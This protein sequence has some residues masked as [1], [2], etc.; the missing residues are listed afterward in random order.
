MDDMGAYTQAIDEQDYKQDVC[1]EE[2]EDT[3]IGLEHLLDIHEADGPDSDDDSD[4]EYRD[5]DEGSVGCAYEI[6]Q[7]RSSVAAACDITKELREWNWDMPWAERLQSVAKVIKYVSMLLD[8]LKTRSYPEID[9]A[10]R[11]YS[12]TRAEAFRKAKIVGATVVGASRRLDAI[13]AAEPF[14]IIVEEA[15]EVM[16]PAL[17]SVLAVPSVCK[18]ELVGDHMQLPAFIQQCWYSL[19]ITQKSIKTSLFE[20]LVMGASGTHDSRK[21]VPTADRSV[22]IPCTILDEQRRMR[23]EIANLTRPEY[24]ELVEIIDHHKTAQQCLGDVFLTQSSDKSKIDSMQRRR[25]LWSGHGR[26]IPG[27]AS[28]IYFWDLKDNKESKPVAG[29]SA[30]NEAEALAVTALCK[31]FRAIG[32]PDSCI[33][34]ITPYKGQKTLITRCLRDEK[35]LPSFVQGGRGGAGKGGRGLGGRYGRG[36]DGRGGGGRG[37]IVQ[38]M[39]DSIFTSTVDRYQGDENDIVIL[40]LVR[41]RPGNRF[42]AL[43]N[44]FIVATSRARLGFYVVGSRGAVTSPGGSGPPHWERFVSDL[45]STSRDVVHTG[46]LNCDFAERRIGPSFPLCCPVHRTSRKEMLKPT[47]APAAP[48]AQAWHTLCTSPCSH[49]MQRCSHL[50]QLPC[51]YYAIDQHNSKCM[52][53]VPRP[54]EK[55]ADRNLVCH[56]IAL[57]DR[58]QT[59]QEALQMY[60]CDAM[61]K[62]SQP[63]CAHSLICTCHQFKSFNNGSQTLPLCK[64]MTGP[65]HLPCGHILLDVECHNRQRFVKESTPPCSEIVAVRFECGHEIRVKCDEKTSGRYTKQCKQDVTFGRPRCFHKVSLQCWMKIILEQWWENEN[66]LEAHKYHSMNGPLVIGGVNYGPCESLCNQLRIPR[67]MVSDAMFKRRCG[68]LVKEPMICSAAFLLT[69]NDSSLPSCSMQVPNVTCPFCQHDIAV[70]CSAHTVLQR[71]IPFHSGVVVQR[72]AAGDVTL[73]ED[74]MLHHNNIGLL[75]KSIVTAL[76]KKCSNGVNI[77][78]NCS[79]V[80]EPHL[81]PISCVDLMSTMQGKMKLPPCTVNTTKTLQCGHEIQVRC[82]EKDNHFDCRAR[83]DTDHFYPCKL[84]SIRRQT[85]AELVKIRRENPACPTVVD[86][87][88]YRC[89]HL[90]KARCSDKLSIEQPLLGKQLE[91]SVVVCG[92][93]YCRRE[94]YDLC[95]HIVSLCLPCGHIEQDVPC[96]IAFTTALKSDE[97]APPC[98]ARVP[99]RHPI[100]GHKVETNCN[101]ASELKNGIWLPWKDKRKPQVRVVSDAAGDIE[102]LVEG[103]GDYP[104]SHPLMKQMPC[105]QSIQISRTCEHDVSVGC[106]EAYLGQIDACEVLVEMEC[107]NGHKRKQLCHLAQHEHESGDYA[108][109]CVPTRKLCSICCKNEVEIECFKSNVNCEDIVNDTVACGHT[110]SWRCGV[111]T[112]PRILVDKP[113]R[114]CLLPDWK[115]AALVQSDDAQFASFL[116]NSMGSVR[117]FFDSFYEKELNFSDECEASREPFVQ[118]RKQIML[119]YVDRLMSSALDLELHVAPRPIEN[120]DSPY[121]LV[122]AELKKGDTAKEAFALTKTTYGRGTALMDLTRRNIDE[123]C[124]PIDGKVHLAIGVVFRHRML[125]SC[126]PF[127]LKTGVKGMERANKQV[128]YHQER[129]FDCVQILIGA[130]D[131]KQGEE[132]NDE[133]EERD[134][135]DED[136]GQVLYWSPGIAI[137]LGTADI[138]V[139]EKCGVCMDHCNREDGYMCSNR[140]FICWDCFDGYIASAMAPDAIK[141]SVNEDGN[142]KCMNCD[143]FCSLAKVAAYGSAAAV[144]TFKELLKLQTKTTVDKNVTEAVETER[145]RLTAEFQRI[146]AIKDAVERR[147]ELIRVDVIDNVLTLRCPQCRLAFLDFSGCL[148]LTCSMCQCGFCAW[149]LKDCGVDA[150]AHVAHCP[151]GKTNGNVFAS[152]EMFEAHHRERKRKKIEDILDTAARADRKIASMAAELL[153][154]DL[155]GTGIKLRPRPR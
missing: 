139:Q 135:E 93:D 146:Q 45:E 66:G 44:R 43:L 104:Y 62:I 59:I 18:L 73:I 152:F 125:T 17:M 101:A 14:A 34:I 12:Q 134:V 9:Q 97:S 50:C 122:F 56:E 117:S 30:C 112:D 74:D 96:N 28:C 41:V 22:P 55:H 72:G 88:V 32:V 65:L 110:V 144:K 64:E 131:P 19:E 76:Q 102:H 155:Q 21:R 100:C 29:L 94:N 149:C 108:Q 40:S 107:P 147:A 79:S 69:L 80:T 120:A 132:G 2:E 25:E 121:T 42:V 58:Q 118:S 39:Q 1:G 33:T 106:T 68:H 48:F 82:C 31:W 36:G 124:S 95:K 75:S 140:H 52:E 54:C 154:P 26:L 38:A 127:V 136:I 8:D 15:C 143:E 16:E 123:Q 89:R 11:D 35:C 87:K 71:F 83:V 91:G 4:S 46:I 129:A 70:P 60:E 109:C 115:N 130:D 5:T 53:P 78:R 67:C 137:L 141:R 84:H 128:L 13:R 99:Y 20:R 10:R 116:A 3:G 103:S 7:F 98:V 138:T 92:E 114:F 81:V 133:A 63:K 6:E 119:R 77:L 111:D 90:I 61:V 126:A 151:E 148:A 105:K 153:Q 27:A 51:H 24:D 113:C 85:C 142:L 86:C 57:N 49:K 145:T 37:I 23:S 47:D 150:H